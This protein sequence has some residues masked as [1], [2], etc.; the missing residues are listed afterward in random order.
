MWIITSYVDTITS[1][2]CTGMFQVSLYL[3]IYLAFAFVYICFPRVSSL[4]LSHLHGSDVS[5][6]ARKSSLA[7]LGR[8]N[9]M[10]LV[11]ETR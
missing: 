5:S 7:G 6:L 11:A 9:S 8:E 4:A 10:S 3:R 1:F 2:G